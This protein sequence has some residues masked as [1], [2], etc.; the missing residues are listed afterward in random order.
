[1]ASISV[2]IS[3]RTC[4][5]TAREGCDVWFFHHVNGVVSLKADFRGFD[6]MRGE[7][8]YHVSIGQGVT[9]GEQMRGA[10]YLPD[11]EASGRP[12]VHSPNMDGPLFSSRHKHS[13]DSHTTL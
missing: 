13:R 11:A 7:H 8:V 2:H 1:M 3:G 10:G 9:P 12:G 6:A 5:S 4:G